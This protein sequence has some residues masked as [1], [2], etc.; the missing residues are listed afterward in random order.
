MEEKIRVKWKR[1]RE[2]FSAGCPVITHRADDTENTRV[3]C[4]MYEAP[5]EKTKHE[6]NCILL[7]N[8]AYPD[9]LG[10][11]PPHVPA[12]RDSQ[13]PRYVMTGRDRIKPSRWRRFFQ[14]HRLENRGGVGGKREGQSVKNTQESL[15]IQVLEN[16]MKSKADLL[17]PFV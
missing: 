13:P 2:R 12:V 6:S 1:G 15:K 17:P 11:G 9:G 7:G 8:A 3:K 4:T 14:G 10:L 16:L 5:E